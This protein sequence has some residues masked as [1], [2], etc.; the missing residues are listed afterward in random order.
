MSN[1]APRPPHNPYAAPRPPQ[2]AA[3]SQPRPQQQYPPQHPQHPPQQPQRAPAPPQQP[4]KYAQP[5]QPKPQPQMPQQ[6]QYAPSPQQVPQS[7]YTNPQPPRPVQPH[8]QQPAGVWDNSYPSVQIPPQSRVQPTVD[9]AA[10]SGIPHPNISQQQP[11]Q[12]STVQPQPFQQQPSQPNTVPLATAPPPQSSSAQ[13]P[14]PPETDSALDIPQTSPSQPMHSPFS[15]ESEESKHQTPQPPQSEQSSF[16]FNPEGFAPQ[17]DDNIK[18]NENESDVMLSEEAAD[19]SKGRK[20]VRIVST[21][22]L[23]VVIVLGVLISSIVVMENNPQMNIFGYRFL[24]I[25]S[26]ATTTIDGASPPSYLTRGN[27]AIVQVMNP[28]QDL[29]EILPMQNSGDDS[30][31]IVYYYDPHNPRELAAHRV[32]DIYHGEPNPFSSTGVD[33]TI[34]LL[35]EETGEP[36]IVN[37]D[38]VLGR[39]TGAISHLGSLINWMRNNNIL[40]FSIVVVIAVVLMIIKIKLKDHEHKDFR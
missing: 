21:I 22:L 7:H 3:G 34:D 32:L 36:R 10:Q 37:G 12:A 13:Q 19:R 39:T 26:P 15:F 33:I 5:Q 31:I 9:V 40:A 20:V 18:F 16:S 27:L 8:S 25:T 17:V 30:T 38:F 1:S 2:P 11:N 35:D 14:T 24:S 6:P 28:V 29:G 23:Y 4:P